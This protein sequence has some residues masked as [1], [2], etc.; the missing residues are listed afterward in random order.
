MR[1]K[2]KSLT[3]EVLSPGQAD[4]QS[5]AL[6]MAMASSC[7]G[8]NPL[9]RRTRRSHDE[10]KNLEQTKELH[11]DQQS[12]MRVKRKSLTLKVPSPGQADSLSLAL[13]M[14][15]ASYCTGSIP[16]GSNRLWVVQSPTLCS[17]SA[18]HQTQP[19]LRGGV[20]QSRPLY[21]PV[22]VPGTHLVENASGCTALGCLGL[23][24]Y[25]M[26]TRGTIT[27]S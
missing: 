11:W 16:L 19:I 18:F 5:L 20:Y 23:P 17:P 9:G 14:A 15:M 25:L 8:S 4:S 13:E 26:Y 12:G 21:V 22:C 2:R 1:V 6:E 24:L 27:G 7:T 3:L 10:H